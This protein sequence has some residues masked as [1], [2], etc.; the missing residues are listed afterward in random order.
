LLTEPDPRFPT[1]D[2]V[3]FVN[4][5]LLN[6]DESNKSQWAAA[7]ASYTKADP[8]GKLH[9]GQLAT[10]LGDLVCTEENAPFVALAIVSDK[11]DRK[12]LLGEEFESVRQRMR[13]ARRETNSASA[14]ARVISALTVTQTCPGAAGL[15]EA[16]WRE[17]EKLELHNPTYYPLPTKPCP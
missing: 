12:E 3:Y 15:S 14:L 5:K 7:E 11:Y 17:V 6:W 2:S 13:A 10:L 16:A 4:L 9:R 8:D 1:F